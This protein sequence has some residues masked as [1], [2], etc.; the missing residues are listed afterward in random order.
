MVQ[1]KLVNQGPDLHHIQ[2]LRLSDGKTA[3]DFVEALKAMKPGTPPPAWA[4][5]VA[6]PNTPL[7]GGESSIM[8]NLEAGNYA[9]VCFI[10]GKDL[11]PHIMKGMVRPL[12]VVA[13]TTPSAPAPVADINIT[14]KDYAWDVSPEITAGK[15]II[16][17]ENAAEQ[18][19][20][21][22]IAKLEAGKTPAD[23]AAWLL[24]QEGPPPGAPMG[25]ISGM[26]KG[27]VVYVPIDLAPGEYG[28]LCFLPDAKDGKEHAAHGMLK[29]FTVK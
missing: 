26:S 17:L 9:M 6:G 4:H 3:N 16:K 21:M 10:P 8:L 27:D 12:T 22:V 25:G 19:H 23:L 14:M 11:V 15:H 1:I 2:F 24:K 7:P 28:L 13:S 29:S 5:D 20:E 18:P